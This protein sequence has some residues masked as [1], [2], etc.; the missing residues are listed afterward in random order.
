[1]AATEATVVVLPI[2]AIITGPPM[3]LTVK[4]V[5]DC[6]EK[7]RNTTDKRKLPDKF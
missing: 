7:Y 6:F 3:P 4:N 5:L 1:M 2:M